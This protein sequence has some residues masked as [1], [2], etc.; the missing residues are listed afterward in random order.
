M[1]PPRE[2]RRKS[3]YWPLLT[4]AYGPVSAN[5]KWQEQC[6]FLFLNIGLS[7]SRYVPQLFYAVKENYL[8]IM[9]VKIVDDVLITEKRVRVQNLISS[10]KL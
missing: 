4:S 9:A 8:E 2:C 10:I 1:V 5:A 3:F 7:Q 6:D